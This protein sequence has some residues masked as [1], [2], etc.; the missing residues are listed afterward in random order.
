MDAQKRSGA[1]TI[2]L[3]V[4]LP[5]GDCGRCGVERWSVKTGTDPDAGLINL[6]SSTPT[7]I[8]TMRSWPAPSPIP[9]NNRVLPYE[10]TIWTVFATMVKFKAEDDSDIHIVLQEGSNASVTNIGELA[11]ADCVGASSPLSAMIAN[12]RSQFNARYTATTSFQTVNAP[13][14]IKGVGM[15]DFLHGQT[16]VAPNGIELHPIL[17]IDFC[18]YSTSPTTQFFEASGGQGSLS[19]T[20]QNGCGW[21]VSAND[22]WIIITSASSGAGN[23]AVTFE[24]RE[25]FTQTARQGTITIGGQ[26]ITVIQDGGLGEDCQYTITP[27]SASYGVNGGAGTI[28]I[29]AENRCAWQ[30]VSSASWITITSSPAGI[31]AG[32]VNYTVASNAGGSARKGTITIAGKIFSIKQKGL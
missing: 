6:A 20:S 30:A 14:V 9:M 12:A 24:V 7:T 2:T 27:S 23:D 17:D 22:S 32:A 21:T 3:N 1:A 26:T 13:V 28:N 4:Q 5:G 31:G 19:I 16:G 15:F 11:C 18:S 25:N 8:T 10:T 29:N